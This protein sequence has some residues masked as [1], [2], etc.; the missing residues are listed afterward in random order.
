MPTPQSQKAILITAWSAILSTA[1]FTIVLQEIFNVSVSENLKYGFIAAVGVAGFVLTFAGREVQALRAF[2]ALF[3]V[4][5]GVQWL[6][7]T[8]IDQVPLIQGWLRNPSFNI[9][10]LAEQL[11]NLA[12]AGIV[13]GFLFLVKKKRQAFY[14]A[15]G[16]T[17][18]P[19]EPVRWLG[20]KSGD[21]WRRFGSI[22]AVCLSL[23]TLAFL[24]IA[25]SPPLDIVGRALPYLPVV[26]LAAALNAFYEEMTYKAS[27]LS[28]LV[29]A[30]G[31]QQSLLLV[32]A[33]FGIWHFYGIPYG[34]IGV[35]LAGFLGWLLAKSMLETGGLFWAWFLHFL[36]DVLIFAFM[37][38]GSVSPGGG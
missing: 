2:F 32:A 29:D 16:E 38:I 30:T 18:A 20:V 1:L 14:L 23:G 34:I 25:G 8:R 19:V 24:L 35:L 15:V 17:N 10:M 36:Q 7:Y 4:L 12:V 31:R 11:L 26:L 3:I 28:V 13:I 22:L 21:R 37:A 9:N 5:S 6:V 27:F 33:Y